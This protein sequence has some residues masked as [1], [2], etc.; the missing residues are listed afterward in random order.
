MICQQCGK[1]IPNDSK[2]CTFCGAEVQQHQPIASKVTKRHQGKMVNMKMRNVCIA[3]ALFAIAF[4][5]SIA[6]NVYLADKVSSLKSEVNNLDNRLFGTNKVVMSLINSK[7]TI[8]KRLA[9]LENTSTTS[10]PST[11]TTKQE[12]DSKQIVLEGT[13][14]GD[15]IIMS[16]KVND[17]YEYGYGVSGYYQRKGRK[18]IAK[19]YGK[20]QFGTLKLEESIPGINDTGEFEGDLTKSSYTGYYYKQGE[21]N[22][23]FALGIK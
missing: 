18:G 16:L 3:L 12:D 22:K 9:L 17:K 2:F 23:K 14:G 21:G 1:E 15:A 8:S 19:L 7:S 5:S 10:Q 6:F 4:I 20:L 11:E 13:L